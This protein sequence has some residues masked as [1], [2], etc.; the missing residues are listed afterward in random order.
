MGVVDLAPSVR[1][2]GWY[3]V[4][5]VGTFIGRVGP[6]SARA[7]L[8]QQF[9]NYRRFAEVALAERALASHASR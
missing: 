3:P 4:S 1:S 7:T 6:L 2:G 8:A 5:T 9:I